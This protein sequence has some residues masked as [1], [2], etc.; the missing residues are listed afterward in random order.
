MDEVKKQKIELNKDER[1]STNNTNENDRLNIILSV[2]DRIYRFFE[3][4]F[5]PGEQPD[6]L[7]LPKWVKVSKKR[8]DMIKNKVQNAK[9]NNLQ[10]RPNRSSLIN[11]SESNNLL[12]GIEYSRISHE[13]ALKRIK[14]IRSDIK[15]IVDKNSLNS[16]QFKVLNVLLW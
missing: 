2:I 11:F 9:N 1:N 12:Q 16:N 6:E 14:N 7:K 15:K 4:K 3:Y 5:L 8:F 10:A 13:E